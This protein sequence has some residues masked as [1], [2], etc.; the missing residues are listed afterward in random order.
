MEKLKEKNTLILTISAVML[1][2]AVIIAISTAASSSKAV[3]KVT[4]TE[5]PV[6]TTAATTAETAKSYIYN[7]GKYRVATGNND[8]LCLRLEPNTTSDRIIYIAS[9]TEVDIIAVWGD[10]GYTVY[11]NTGGWLSLN[12]LEL[13]NSAASTSQT[14]SSTEA[15][16]Q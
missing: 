14:A 7:P 12:Y 6:S 2:A 5:A 8:S 4:E 13:I 16:A 11:G 9:G 1:I 3:K 15:A 10:W